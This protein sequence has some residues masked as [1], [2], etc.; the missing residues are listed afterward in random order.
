[1]S[2]TTPTNRPDLEILIVDDDAM[3]RLLHKRQV[4]KAN[5]GYPVTLCKHGQEAA[6]YLRANAK[7]GVSYLVLLD[8]NMPVMNGWEFLE[9]CERHFGHL[10]LHIVVVT[11]SINRMDELRAR[12]YEQVCGFCTKPLNAQRW[13]EL[14]GK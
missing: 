4:E 13:R 14:L 9:E 5:S 12:E 10:A 8:L 7:E 6:D 3:I 1:M 2:K 11:S